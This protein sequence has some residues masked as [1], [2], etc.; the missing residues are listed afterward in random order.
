MRHIDNMMRDFFA[1]IHIPMEDSVFEYTL[2]E[3]TLQFVS[4]KSKLASPEK[5]DPGNARYFDMTV[6]TVESLRTTRFLD[7]LTNINKPVFLTGQT[8]T[9]K[10]MITQNYMNENRMKQ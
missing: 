9:G 6:P 1:Q 2:N 8:G 5:F 4:W 3:K 10:T 7:Q